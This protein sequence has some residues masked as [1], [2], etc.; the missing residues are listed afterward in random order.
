M[1]FSIAFHYCSIYITLESEAPQY[2][3]NTRN[4]ISVHSE[5]WTNFNNIIH[6]DRFRLLLVNACYIILTLIIVITSKCKISS[7]I[8]RGWIA[9][10]EQE[11]RQ[12]YTVYCMMHQALDDSDQTRKYKISDIA[13]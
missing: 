1:H 6:H 12:G 9:K 11:T 3:I 13:L 5:V 8:E 7:I 4:R 2:K 10:K